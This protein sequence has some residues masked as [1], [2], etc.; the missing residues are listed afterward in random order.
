MVGLSVDGSSPSCSAKFE[1]CEMKHKTPEEQA[2]EV[3]RQFADA[4]I[5]LCYLDRDLRYRYINKWLADMNG[6]SPELHLGKTIQ[7]VVEDIA[8]RVVPQLR[9]VLETGEPLIDGVAEA[10]T[11]ATDGTRRVFR[12]SYHPAFDSE[13][14]IVGVTCVVQVHD[15][16]EDLLALIEAAP[17]GTRSL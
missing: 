14:K 17:G 15:I 1:K 10:A 2:E 7:E 16:L 12:H 9:R 8:V 5:G 11:P 13:G 4:P 3:L 6:V